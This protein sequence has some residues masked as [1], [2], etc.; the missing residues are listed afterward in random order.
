MPIVLGCLLSVE[1][2]VMSA[3]FFQRQKALLDGKDMNFQISLVQI[4]QETRS[5]VAGDIQDSDFIKLIV[6]VNICWLDNPSKVNF[7]WHFCKERVNQRW[8]FTGE[9]ICEPLFW[10]VSWIIP[11]AMAGIYRQRHPER[12]VFY[13]VLF[14]YFDEFVAEYENRFERARL[15]SSSHSK[16]C[17]EIPRLWQS[18]VWLCA[19]SMQRLQ[20]W[21]FIAFFMSWERILPLL[22]R[23][24]TWGV[25]QVRLNRMNRAQSARLA[26]SLKLPYI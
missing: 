19:D 17:W 22:P 5:A 13:R 24:E 15:F 20:E 18:E 25:G 3:I 14:H 16:S 6:T 4:E 7:C 12:T 1:N 23:Q 8:P 2:V 21:V 9:D 10:P 26:Y 11:A